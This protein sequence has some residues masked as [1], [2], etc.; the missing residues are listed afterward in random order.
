MRRPAR[1]LPLVAAL[2]VAVALGGCGFGAGHGTKDAS[3]QITSDFGTHLLGH[4][5]ESKIPGSETVM[6]LTQRHFKVSTKYGGGFIESIDGH[7][8][9]S[10][11][12]DWFYY[13]NGIQAPI[14]A[15]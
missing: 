13:V 1:P 5:A 12:L 11:H 9:G 3:V 15:G 8:G 7:S 4:A 2:V 14:G 10:G 6:A